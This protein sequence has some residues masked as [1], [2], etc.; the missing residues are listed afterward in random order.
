MTGSLCFEFYTR[1]AITLGFL[2]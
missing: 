2:E 1:A